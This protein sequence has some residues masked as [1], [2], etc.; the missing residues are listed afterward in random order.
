MNFL[1][2]IL[3][4]ATFAGVLADS[5]A[6]R[7]VVNSSTDS[8]LNGLTL[9]VS[10][11]AILLGDERHHPTASHLTDCG[12]LVVGGNDYAGDDDSG[13]FTIVGATR[14]AL[15]FTIHGGKLTYKNS[16]ELRVVQQG[17]AYRLSIHGSIEVTIDAK[18]VGG[19]YSVSDFSPTG[20][21]HGQ[22]PQGPTGG[23]GSP[24]AAPSS[25]NS[26][27]NAGRHSGGTSGGS[28]GGSAGTGPVRHP[29]GGGK[30]SGGGNPGGGGRPGGGNQ[31]SSGGGWHSSGG[32]KNTSKPIGSS[33][34]R[35]N[36]TARYGKRAPKVSV[37]DNEGASVFTQNPFSLTALVV[38]VAIL[39]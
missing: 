33:T 27:G 5:T 19:N 15:G 22:G 39:L 14:A 7:P 35:P 24:G 1:S 28:P 11:D 26:S 36:S 13:F 20:I 6:F 31:P 29:S 18:V 10:G 25:N 30:P 32:Y 23:H 9:Y 37:S 16:A 8:K 4:V 3:V 2:V 38:L 21:C 34:S 17:S 12:A